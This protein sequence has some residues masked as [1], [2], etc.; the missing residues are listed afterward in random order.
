MSW[1][2]FNVSGINYRLLSKLRKFSLLRIRDYSMLGMSYH[3][4]NLTITKFK[5][6]LARLNTLELR[7]LRSYELANKRRR[8]YLFTITN[9][10]NEKESEKEFSSARE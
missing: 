10:L 4:D 9:E 1:I 2:K 5:K 8:M 6:K 3:Y 7:K